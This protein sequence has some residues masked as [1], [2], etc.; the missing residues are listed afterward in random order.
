MNNHDDFYKAW[1]KFI[2]R[3]TGEQIDIQRGVSN[4][5]SSR[6]EIKD[7]LG[8]GIILN[9]SYGFLT[10]DFR[11][12]KCKWDVQDFINAAHITHIS[13]K[14]NMATINETNWSPKDYPCRIYGADNRFKIRFYSSDEITEFDELLESYITVFQSVIFTII[15]LK[16]ISATEKLK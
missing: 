10:V 2:V 8:T 6:F 11:D 3:F 16:I 4:T 13:Q 5:G 14:F 15:R 12:I 1:L 7:F 9:D